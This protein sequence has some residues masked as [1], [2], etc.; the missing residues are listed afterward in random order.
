MSTFFNLVD[1]QA[2]REGFVWANA[3]NFYEPY[4]CVTIC[5]AMITMS[6]LD[7]AAFSLHSFY[8]RM[9]PIHGG[10]FTGTLAGGGEANLDVPIGTG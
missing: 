8:S 9:Y 4:D 2:R 1:E 7:G 3:D 10:A 5:G 6:R